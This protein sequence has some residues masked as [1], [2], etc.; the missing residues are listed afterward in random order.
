MIGE[1]PARRVAL[2]LLLVVAAVIWVGPYLWMVSTSFKTLDEIV[3]A[4]TAPLPSSLSLEAY[5]E[6]FAS[7]PVGRYLFNTTLMATLIA[8]LQRMHR[9]AP[10]S[11]VRW[12]LKSSRKALAV[13]RSAAW[14]W[15]RWASSLPMQ[16]RIRNWSILPGGL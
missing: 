7:V 9:Q 12:T 4:P 11:P 1:R 10:C 2:M 15:N 5:A 8:L 13:A 3:A 6:V 16:G 14:R